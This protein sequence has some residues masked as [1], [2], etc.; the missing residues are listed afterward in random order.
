MFLFLLAVA[1]AVGIPLL[2]KAEVA[3]VVVLVYSK[4]FI[5]LRTQLLLSV[6]VVQTG[7]LL[8]DKT[9]AGDHPKLFLVLNKSFQQVAAVAV[10]EMAMR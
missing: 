10:A 7:I 6:P 1:L 8:V 3:V 4:Q 9:M 5:Y 2:I